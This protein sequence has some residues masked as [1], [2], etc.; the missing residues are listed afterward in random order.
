MNTDNFVL[1]KNVC[2]CFGK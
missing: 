1:V 2:T